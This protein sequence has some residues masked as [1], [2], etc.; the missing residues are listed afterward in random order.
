MLLGSVSDCMG[1]SGRGEEGRGK[2]H[3]AERERGVDRIHGV[4]I[5]GFGGGDGLDVILAVSDDT[6]VEGILEFLGRKPNIR[7]YDDAKL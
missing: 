3:P 6:I 5:H 1:K 4:W 7:I 2:Y